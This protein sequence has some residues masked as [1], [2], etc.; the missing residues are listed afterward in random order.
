VYTE[1]EDKQWVKLDRILRGTI[2]TM[3][4]GVPDWVKEFSVTP[5]LPA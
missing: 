1:E 5:S 2:E 3:E 4:E